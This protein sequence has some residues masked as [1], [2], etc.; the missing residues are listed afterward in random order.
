MLSWNQLLPKFELLLH[1]TPP[2]F[3]PL[4]LLHWEKVW[5]SCDC[6]NWQTP[7]VVALFSKT[8]CPPILFSFTFHSL[9]SSFTGPVCCGFRIH[10]SLCW[11]YMVD[12]LKDRT[13]ALLSLPLQL[14]PSAL[15][16]SVLGFCKIDAVY[17]LR[18]CSRL[19]QQR[20]RKAVLTYLKYVVFWT[21]C[22]HFNKQ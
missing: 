18:G 17:R 16:F 14:L 5:L 9:Q 13:S 20:G 21:G 3:Q 22:T 8:F 2:S 15:Y 11:C 6:W 4:H 12:S 10:G 19:V 7:V 1:H